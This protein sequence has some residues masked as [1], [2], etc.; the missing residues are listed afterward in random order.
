MLL[1]SAIQPGRCTENTPRGEKGRCSRRSSTRTTGRHS[2]RAMS[3]Q[4]LES[5][6]GQMTV[7]EFCARTGRSIDDLL[8][9]CGGSGSPRSKNLP[10]TPSP[11]PKVGKR[12]RATSLDLVAL[13][14]RV[15]TLLRG[16]RK[17]LGGRE[18]AD[19]TGT[20]LPQLRGSLKRLVSAKRVRFDGQTSARRYWA[21]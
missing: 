21:K 15:V 17:G 12:T 1:L 6:V 18:L 8:R 14:E 9:F 5:F 16:A 11:A 20:S 13:D 19:S 3:A 2:I 4:V 7:S 10:R